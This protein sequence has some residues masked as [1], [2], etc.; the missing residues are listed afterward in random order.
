MNKVLR[1]CSWLALAGLLSFLQACQPESTP[2]PAHHAKAVSSAAGL[3]ALAALP[4]EA[5][6]V[7]RAIK[8]GGPFAYD[9]DGVVFGNFEHVLPKQPRGYYHEYTVKTPGARNRGA[10]RIIAG[11]SGE[12]YYTADHYQ[13]FNRIQE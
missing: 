3:V 7:L 12:Y 6:E 1:W 5:H 11:N 9:R 10:R 4:P 13:T 8:Q 2:V